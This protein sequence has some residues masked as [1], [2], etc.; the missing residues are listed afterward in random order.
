MGWIEIILLCRVKIQIK[1]I[2]Y[3]KTKKLKLKGC[4]AIIKIKILILQFYK[5]NQPL[6]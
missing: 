3:I 6:K 2:S 1:Y 5:F 4:L